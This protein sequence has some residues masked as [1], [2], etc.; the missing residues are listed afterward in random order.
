MSSFVLSPEYE[1]LR[2][3]LR[4]FAEDEI[5]PHAAEADATGEYRRYEYTPDLVSP[6][7]IPGERGGQHVATGIEHDEYGHPGYT[8][9]IHVGMQRTRQLGEVARR[10]DAQVVGRTAEERRVGISLPQRVE[11]RVREARLSGREAGRARDVV[12]GEKEPADADIE[13]RRALGDEVIEVDRT[14]VVDVEPG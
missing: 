12:K 4:R 8:P 5:A 9:E 14:L 3:A 13:H 11:Q 1:E 10:M 6:M 2:K 7:G